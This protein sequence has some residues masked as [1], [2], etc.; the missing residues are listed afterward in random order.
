M[1]KTNKV[2]DKLKSEFFLIENRTD[3]TDDEKVSQLIKVTSAICAGAALQPMPF[4][5]TFVLTPIQGYM[6]TRIAAVRGIP[7]SRNDALTTITEISGTIGLGLLAQQLVIGAYKTFI[8]YLGGLFTA[9]M[10]FSLTYGIGRVMDQYLISKSK[11]QILSK[12]VLKEVYRKAKEEGKKEQSEQKK[13]KDTLETIQ[14]SSDKAIRFLKTN[15]DDIIIITSLQSIRGRVQLSETDN[16]VLA[17]FQRYSGSTNSLE[18]T[19]DYLKSMSEDQLVGVVSNVKGILHEMEFVKIENTDGDSITA[20]MF[21]DTN[22]KGFDVLLT[23]QDAGSSWEIQL[24][25]TDDASYV[26]EWV[27]KYPDG[28]ILVSKEIA[29]ELNIESSGLSNEELT[30]KVESFV[31]KLISGGEGASIWHLIPTLSLISIAFSVME[32][33]KRFIQEE[34]TFKEFKL[35]SMRVTGIKIGKFAI[36]ITALSI[37]VLNVVVG[38]A[39]VARVL[40]ALVSSGSIPPTIKIPEHLPENI[41]KNP[42][43]NK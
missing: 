23:D 5:D 9:P 22:H 26:Q 43:P 29:E 3:I 13:K 37:P 36:L 6:G 21:P 27:D 42:I 7:I 17:A 1:S 34:I 30:L 40:Y 14:E 11:G 2:I 18:E 32:L 15:F 25:T 31:D 35:L 38:T 28:E 24:K 8:P 19:T 12:E 10:V 41:Y 16:I 4:A 33:H 39:L 20:A